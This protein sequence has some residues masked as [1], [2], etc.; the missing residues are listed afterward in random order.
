MA[1]SYVEPE[2]RPVLGFAQL[3]A[4]ARR[5]GGTLRCFQALAV[6]ADIRSRWEVLDSRHQF[7]AGP[8]IEAPS[9]EVVGE[10]D[11][12]RASAR[13]CLGLCSGEEP[14][15]EPATS[16]ARLHPEAL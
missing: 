10:M 14:R 3:R 11:G 6:P 5:L 8:L 15:P 16:E 1:G 7:V 4:V 2:L 12:L 9:L 13:R